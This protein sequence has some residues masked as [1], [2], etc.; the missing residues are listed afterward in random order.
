MYECTHIMKGLARL[1]ENAP[2]ALEAVNT[3]EGSEY[4]AADALEIALK[5]PSAVVLT[6]VIMPPGMILGS[7]PFL[8]ALRVGA[9]TKYSRQ[10]EFACR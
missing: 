6:D 4:S 1:S 9:E 2:P 7:T 5:T 3:H 10:I 8:F